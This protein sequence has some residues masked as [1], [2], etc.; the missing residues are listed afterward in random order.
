M[1][2]LFNFFLSKALINQA[3]VSVALEILLFHTFNV[4]C[5]QLTHHHK[6][7]LFE[8]SRGSAV[9]NVLLE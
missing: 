4:V 9:I 5:S 1:K 8:L 3:D 7:A 2:D 6:L